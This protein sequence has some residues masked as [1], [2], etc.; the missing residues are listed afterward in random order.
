[1]RRR[2]ASVTKR[3]LE[4]NCESLQSLHRGRSDDT[5]CRFSLTTVEKGDGQEGKMKGTFKEPPESDGATWEWPPPDQSC[6][7]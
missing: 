5:S 3:Y 7:Q 2:G 6:T 1:M 4:N